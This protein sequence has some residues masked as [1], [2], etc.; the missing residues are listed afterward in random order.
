MTT[1]IAN[2]RMYAATP[3][4]SAAWAR[5]FEAVAERAG[6][7]LEVIAHKAPAPLDALWAR[8]DMGAVFMCGWPFR[9]AD[10]Q[11]VPVAAPV[12]EDEDGPIYR[13]DL[14]ACADGPVERLEDAFGGVMAWT[15]EGSHSGWNAPRRLLADHAR[16]GA[17]FART[18]GPVVTPRGAIEAVLSGDADVA[19][20]DSY[21]HALLRRHEPETAAKLRT[22]ARTA[23]A[24]IPL[25]VASPGA[26]MGAVGALRGA[27]AALHEEEACAALLEALA[28][29]RFATVLAED[30]AVAETWA[31]EAEAAG[32]PRIA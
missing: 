16:G 11:P 26:S 4:V 22:V 15:V 18:V 3:E 29:R 32:Y 23:P 1:L 12:P 24:P 13:T 17:L 9:R 8:G 10:P 6:V 31:A 25:L 14:V 30:Y 5:L 21:F 2:A 28:L 20:L 7:P 19:P 27:F